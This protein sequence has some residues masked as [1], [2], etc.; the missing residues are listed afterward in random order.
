MVQ[1]ERE[2]IHHNVDARVASDDVLPSDV[3]VEPA[4]DIAVDETLP[5]SRRRPSRAVRA[6]DWLRLVDTDNLA[7]PDYMMSYCLDKFIGDMYF[8]T[9]DDPQLL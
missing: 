9:L 8:L 3:T 7:P 1:T 5:L 4:P 2:R 6:P